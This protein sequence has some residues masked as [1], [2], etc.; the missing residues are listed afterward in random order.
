[1]IRLRIQ[2]SH[3]QGTW[4]VLTD[5]PRPDCPDC[6]GDGGIEY[7]YGD[8]NGEY[9]DS[10]WEPCGCWNENRRWRLLPLPRLHRLL[11]RWHHRRDPWGPGSYSNEPPF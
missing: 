7:P 4:L 6:E 5:T 9:A 11:R 3:Q 8:E 1:M 10:N 2:V